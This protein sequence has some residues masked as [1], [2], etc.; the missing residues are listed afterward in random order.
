MKK[1]IILLLLLVQVSYAGLT[2]TY[3]HI[4]VINNSVLDV[5]GAKIDSI[6]SWD[7]S[8]INFYDGTLG[9]G[10]VG[11]DS[12]FHYYGGDIQSYLYYDFESDNIYGKIHIYGTGLHFDH[13]WVRG[14]LLDG[15]PLNL[16]IRVSSIDPE[17][18][19]LHEV[20]EPATA[21]ILGIGLIL[22]RR[23]K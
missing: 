1:T 6:F 10:Y 15:D 13:K 4:N 21:A 17:R 12:E 2:G 11:G 7:D 18:V 3:D 19:V 5:D 16:Y 22:A 23:K 9:Y 14:T 8:R 20:P